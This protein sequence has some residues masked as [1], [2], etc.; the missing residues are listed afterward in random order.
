MNNEDKNTKEP[1]KK[2]H[3]NPL[4]LINLIIVIVVAVIVVYYVV[5]PY[6]NCIRDGK[7]T[8]FCTFNTAW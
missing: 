2:G 1:N 3:Q 7:S 8:S 5:S 4:V 6:Q